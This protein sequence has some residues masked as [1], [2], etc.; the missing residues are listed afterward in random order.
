M[1]SQSAGG[2][3]L[4]DADG[5]TVGRTSTLVAWDAQVDAA[6]D[7]VNV[8]PLQADLELTGRRG[9]VRSHELSLTAPQGFLDDPETVYPVII[10]PD[11]SGL[12]RLRDTFVREGS[13]QQGSVERL[14]VGRLHGSTNPYPAHSFVKFADPPF[15]ADEI[16]SAQAGL[17]QYFAPTCADR[18]MNVHAVT[19]AWSPTMVWANRPGTTTTAMTLTTANRGLGACAGGWTT[20]DVTN[21]TKAWA[22]GTLANHGM[23]LTAGTADDSTFERRFCS[24]DPDTSTANC[25]TTWRR[26]YLDVTVSP[27]AYNED[28]DPSAWEDDVADDLA[29]ESDVENGELTP[30]GVDAYQ[31]EDL[32]LIADE[33]GITLQDAVTRY[34]WQDDFALAVEEISE[35]L[36]ESFSYGEATEGDDPV[37]VIHLTGDAPAEADAIVTDAGTRVNLDLQI[38]NDAI[39][40]ALEIEE[41]VSDAHDAVVYAVGTDDVGTFYDEKANVV[42][43]DVGGFASGDESIETDVNVA[44]AAVDRSVVIPNVEIVFHD[45]EAADEE[46]IRGGVRIA[47]ANGDRCTSGFPAKRTHPKTGK[48]NYGIVTAAHC[49]NTT[50][51]NGFRDYLNP[52]GIKIWNSRGDIHYQSRKNMG[53]KMG[54]SFQYAP[55]KFRRI[56]GVRAPYV[57]KYLCMYGDTTRGKKNGKATCAKVAKIGTARGKY[58]GL[59]SMTKYVSESGDSGGPWFSGGLAYG[60]HSGWHT[61]TARKRSQFTP[62]SSTL[63]TINTAIHR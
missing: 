33:E 59:V 14:M 26:P 63:K 27:E 20:L 29:A 21:M 24:M 62:V 55:G 31:L 58:K 18:R 15:S 53:N 4:A 1:L 40:T 42:R 16:V 46:A 35:Q 41:I 48:V 32:K 7:P 12:T 43:A 54:K 17:W 38:E 23:R 2:L 36:P 50:T 51:Y 5:Q 49:R 47:A 45:E 19:G 25:F 52:P 22:N 13:T 39:Y 61:R 37:P 8:V 57:G 44:L 60:V 56:T 6:G 9:A 3:R 28:E 30:Y 34:G 10:D 11:V